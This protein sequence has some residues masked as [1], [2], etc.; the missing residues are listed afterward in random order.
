[1]TTTATNSENLTQFGRQFIAVLAKY[2][3]VTQSVLRTRFNQTESQVKNEVRRL[4][5]KGFIERRP[6]VK[7]QFYYR[8]TH[9]AC[10]KFG[11]SNRLCSEIGVQGL[12]IAY[13]TVHFLATSNPPMKL[14]RKAD[15]EFLINPDS[16]EDLPQITGRFY[17]DEEDGRR[18]LGQL[19]IDC[20]SSAPRLVKKMSAFVADRKDHIGFRELVARKQ[21]R[22]CY[23]AEVSSKADAI[24]K[25]ALERNLEPPR[26][27]ICQDLQYL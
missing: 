14:L 11:L 26:I 13:G 8:L 4:T 5:A 16:I 21:L 18:R 27:H 1:M 7:G 23:V 10:R 2:R 20:R 9:R 19:F 22:F 17:L 3:V 24:V 25:A 12:R 6:F 15:V